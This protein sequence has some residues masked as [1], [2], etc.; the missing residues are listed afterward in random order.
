MAALEAAASIDPSV[1]IIAWVDEHNTA[2]R[3]VAVRLGLTN[4]GLRVDISDGEV[5]LAYSDRPVDLIRSEQR[6]HVSSR[7]DRAQSVRELHARRSAWGK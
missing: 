1:A 6:I 7:D 2:S 5:R 4:R 3:R